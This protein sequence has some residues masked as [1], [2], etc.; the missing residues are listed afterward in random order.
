VIRHRGSFTSRYTAAAAAIIVAIFSPAILPL[1][2]YAWGA[3]AEKLVASKAV[4]TLPPEIRG[5]FEANKDFISQHVSE[6]MDSLEKHP[7]S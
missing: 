6:P 7:L 2:A 3:S 5:Y 4:D 1:P